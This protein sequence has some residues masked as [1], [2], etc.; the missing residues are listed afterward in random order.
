MTERDPERDARQARAIAQALAAEEAEERIRKR[1]PKSERP[2]PAPRSPM[3]PGWY[4]PAD[5]VNTMR[6]WDGVGWS[7]Y[8]SI[9]AVSV[10]QAAGAESDR[11][12]RGDPIEYLM[13]GFAISFLA[14]LIGAAIEQ[15]IVYVLGVAIG[16]LVMSIGVV[17]LGV[18]IGV[19][20]ADLE[21]KKAKG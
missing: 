12:K 17:G 3:A 7:E 2:V 1:F 10:V 20:A 15:E 11:S 13:V 4:A 19:R 5:Q 9:P 21:R 18:Q 16:G 8:L 6:F 14:G